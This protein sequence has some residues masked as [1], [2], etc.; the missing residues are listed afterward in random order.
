VKVGITGK[1]IIARDTNLSMPAGTCVFLEDLVEDTLLN[2]STA[3]SYSFIINDTTNAPRFVLHIGAPIA[4]SSVTPSCFYSTN[5]QAILSGGIDSWSTTWKDK[6]GNTIAVHNNVIASDTLKNLAPGKYIANVLGKVSACTAFNDTIVVAEADTIKTIAIISNPL[7]SNLNS[8]AISVSSVVGGVAPYSFSWSNGSVASSISNINNGVYTL[9]V[10]DANN[11]KD[12][13]YL[14]VNA[15]SG[16]SVNF[17][18]TADTLLPVSTSTV[19]FNNYSNAYT[20]LSWDFGDGN[21]SASFSPVHSY[22]VPGIYN[23][24]LIASDSICAD[25]ALASVVVLSPT[26]IDQMELSNTVLIYNGESGPVV[27]FNL[28]NESRAE[29]RMMNVEGKVILRKDLVALQNTEITSTEG[30]SSG[31]YLLEVKIEGKSLVKKF[32]K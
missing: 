26:L 17:S 3:P 27:R 2:F 4:K 28:Q 16:L 13:S 10:T 21:T 24:S 11:C 12:T 1:Y 25:T 30:L 29:I 14:A 5:G 18:V 31:L 6:L 15:V 19:G 7:C 32:T 8:G 22:T 9:V 20:S 23:I